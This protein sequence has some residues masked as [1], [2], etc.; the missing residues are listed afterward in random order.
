[1][2]SDAG[3]AAETVTATGCAA[4]LT[5][6]SRK[7]KAGYH[8]GG[9]MAASEALNDVPLDVSMNARAMLTAH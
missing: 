1:M 2:G 4:Q 6:V 3:T 9:A 7:R 5:G 8:S